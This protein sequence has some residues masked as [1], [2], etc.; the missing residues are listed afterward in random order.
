M[1]TGSVYDPNVRIK[2]LEELY[3]IFKN[4]HRKSDGKPLLELAPKIEVLL[5]R[6]YKKEKKDIVFCL[7]SSESM[8]HFSKK[9]H[10]IK[11]NYI[12]Y[13]KFL[14]KGF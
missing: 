13:D 9:A 7:D 11:F 10:A 2:C 14:P 8:D 1:E 3:E 5:R 4:K 12:H 6:S